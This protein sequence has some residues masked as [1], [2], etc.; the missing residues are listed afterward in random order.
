MIEMHTAVMYK[1]RHKT[2]LY[3]QYIYIYN[4]C[5]HQDSLEK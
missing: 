5:I 4:F 3:I 2:Y 1:Y